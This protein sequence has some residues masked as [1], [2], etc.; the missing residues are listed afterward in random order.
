M[1]RRKRAGSGK[2]ARGSWDT[3]GNHVEKERKAARP[4]DPAVEKLRMETHTLLVAAGLTQHK[5][6]YGY[7]WRL[8]DKPKVNN[9]TQD[10]TSPLAAEV[11][12]G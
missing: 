11:A 8:N 3:G 10:P 6:R 1:N 5:T 12:Q 7:I 9:E 4:I 2:R